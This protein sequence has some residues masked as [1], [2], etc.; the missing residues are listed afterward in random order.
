MDKLSHS[1]DMAWRMREAS[2]RSAGSSATEALTPGS[3]KPPDLPAS[4]FEA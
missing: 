2:V 4:G 1:E 3:S